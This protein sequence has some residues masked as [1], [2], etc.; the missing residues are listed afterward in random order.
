MVPFGLALRACPTKGEVHLDHQVSWVPAGF[1][2][3]ELTLFSF[4]FDKCAVGRY[5]RLPQYPVPRQFSTLQ[6][7]HP[8]MTPHSTT[9]VTA[10]KW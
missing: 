6:P 4:V 1:L 10:A 3:H 5:S 2:R 7:Y 9:T 8:L